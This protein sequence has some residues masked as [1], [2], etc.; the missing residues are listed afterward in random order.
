MKCDDFFAL[1][2]LITLWPWPL[3]RWPWKFVVDLMSCDVMSVL[4]LI[5]IEQPPA[6]LFT[7]WQ[8]FARVMSR[9]DLDLWPLDL[10]LLWSI[11]RPVFK[12]CVKFEQNRTIR[13]RVIDDLA[14]YR[15]QIFEGVVFT[16]KDLTGAWT[17]LHQTWRGHTAIISA[18]RVC[19]R[20]E[21]CCCIF[22][23]WPLTVELCWKR[24][25]I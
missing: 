14:H 20:V 25:Q 10:E 23:R 19:F 2:C 18:H 16:W 4:N 21:I 3:T 12:L 17:E 15:H 13:C 9:C 22:K 7:I 6:E 5:E 1:I 8:I 11:G 24:C